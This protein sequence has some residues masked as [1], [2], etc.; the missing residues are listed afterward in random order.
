MRR[1]R[2]RTS[3]LDRIMKPEFETEPDANQGL[4]NRPLIVG[5]DVARTDAIPKV[6]GAAQYDADL[7]FP[8]MLHTAVL[9]SPPPHAR[10]ISIHTSAPQAVPGVKA[11]AAAADTA[12]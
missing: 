2:S 10:I 9:P 6:T 3:R 12:N 8:G 11:V 1:L 7:H 5:Q 4:S